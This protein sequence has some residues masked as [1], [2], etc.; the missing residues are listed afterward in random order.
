MTAEVLPCPL[1]YPQVEGAA[2][3]DERDEPPSAAGGRSVAVGLNGSV[4]R[5][6][7]LP[8]A[9]LLWTWSGFWGLMG[10]TGSA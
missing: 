4:G 5:R 9:S 3:G 1:E 8:A 10:N 2:M 6:G 7:V